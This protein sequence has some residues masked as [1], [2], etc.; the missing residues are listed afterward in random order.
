MFMRFLKAGAAVLD[1][2][3]QVTL[4]WPKACSQDFPDFLFL[5]LDQVLDKHL[6]AD[7]RM[8]KYFPCLI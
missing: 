7:A 6:M 3:L 4:S 2:A 5:S 1:I 8:M